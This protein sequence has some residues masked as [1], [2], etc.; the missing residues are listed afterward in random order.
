MD[1][2]DQAAAVAFY[3]RLGKV[4]NGTVGKRER[5]LKLLSECSQP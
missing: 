4:W 1:A 5:V 2:D 3:G